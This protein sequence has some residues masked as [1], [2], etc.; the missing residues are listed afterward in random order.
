MELNGVIIRTLNDDLKITIVPWALTEIDDGSMD[1]NKVWSQ[2][3]NI[4]SNV[5][6][7]TFGTDNAG[8]RFLRDFSKKFPE[9]IPPSPPASFKCTAYED[10]DWEERKIELLFSN[11]PVA[12]VGDACSVKN[13]GE[14]LTSHIGLLSPTTRCSAHA[15]SCAI[16]WITTSKTMSVPE[17]V[18]FASGIKPILKHFK[19]SGKSSALLQQCLEIMAMKAFKLTTWCP[20][21]MANLLECSAR[22][23]KILFPICDMLA[24][25]G[26][27]EGE[28][29]YFLSPTCLNILHMMADL[30]EFLVSKFLRKPDT[31]E[32]TLFNVSRLSETFTKSTSDLKTPLFDS[33]LGGLSED[34][35]GKVKYEKFD[36][37]GNKNTITLNNQH[38]PSRR[39]MSKI[40]LI[41]E[42]SKE[43]KG[44]IIANL[45]KNVEDQSQKGRI[46][47]FASAFD[48]SRKCDKATRISY[49]KE[50]HLIYD[51][52]YL[53]ELK[54]DF[55][56]FHVSIKYPSKIKCS[57]SELISEFNS[58]WPVICKTWLKFK[59]TKPSSSVSKCFWTHILEKHSIS[60][61]NLADLILIIFAI[62]L[63]TGPW[64]S[65]S[66]LSKICY[67]D[68]VCIFSTVLETLY[69]NF[70]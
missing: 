4:I 32:A 42:E 7:F 3:V 14:I 23:V 64:E 12:S 21:R 16:R 41:N 56:D 38:Q 60:Y 22:T 43:L 31:D 34:N 66:K 55:K 17:V 40:E 67:R 29:S 61:P 26:V 70:R 39:S 48:L 6:K 52:E 63:G 35:Y 36:E 59:D 57:E 5:N 13:A 24:T 47:E 25:T 62:L 68:I 27:K 69:L 15:A 50:L 53:H 18:T 58:S 54:E 44:R 65:F 1:A 49:I 30:K 46:L 2:V 9:E 10:I 37:K 45:I 51:S 8:Q 11:W 19:L 20:A 33:F 28:A